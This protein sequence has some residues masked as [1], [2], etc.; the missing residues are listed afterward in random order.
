MT[1]TLTDDELA[2]RKQIVL[3]ILCAGHGK[4]VSTKDIAF[5]L[6][7]E[8][9]DAQ[10][11][12]RQH[13]FGLWRTNEDLSCWRILPSVY[14][15]RSVIRTVQFVGRQPGVFSPRPPRSHRSADCMSDSLGL[16]M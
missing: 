6:G 8:E 9:R 13:G 1:E 11:W 5:L 4:D 15:Q 14:A 3:D 2:E 10:A 12:L 16:P 7:V